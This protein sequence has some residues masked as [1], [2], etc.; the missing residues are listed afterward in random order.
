[1]R[2]HRLSAAA[3][4]LLLPLAV[5][6]CCAGE[7]ELT[8]STNSDPSVTLARGAGPETAV[9]LTG[10]VGQSEL[11]P[12]DFGELYRAAQGD[13]TVEGVAVTLAGNDTGTGEM[14]TVVL[15]LPLPLREG[16]RIPVGEAVPVTMTVDVRAR[17]GVFDL[18]DADEAGVGVWTG[19]YSFPPPEFRPSFQAASATGEIVVERVGGGSATLRLDVTTTSGDGATLRLRGPVSLHA[20]RYTPPC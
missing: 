10:M 19:T 15:A 1:M 5:S 9:T 6:A 14:V 11:S 2:L 8:V 17:W 12:Q 18:A 3:L 13:G 4:A 16:D 7:E 20:Q